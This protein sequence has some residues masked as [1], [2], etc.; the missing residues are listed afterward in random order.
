VTV[1]EG[2]LPRQNRLDEVLVNSVA[3]ERY[4]MTL[5][6]EHELVTIA[7]GDEVVDVAAAEVIGSTA[8][9]VVGVGRF[10]EEVLR[11]EYDYDGL[12]LTTPALTERYLQSGFPYRFQALHLAPG[13]DPSAVVAGYEALAGEDYGLIVRSTDEQRASAQLARCA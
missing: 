9:R 2:R 6:S 7:G 10:P 1:L 8:V 12:L 4:G 5:G 11:D 13:A 3:T